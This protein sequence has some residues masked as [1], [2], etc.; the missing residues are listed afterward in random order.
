MVVF[1]SL[2]IEFLFLATNNSEQTLSVF[3]TGTLPS[4][5]VLVGAGIVY[6]DALVLPF[7]L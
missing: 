2:P 6:L 4:I 3:M 5:L 1:F 7:A